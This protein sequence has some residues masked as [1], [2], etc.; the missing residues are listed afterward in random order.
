ME[1][2]A[3]RDAIELVCKWLCIAAAKLLLYRFGSETKVRD[4]PMQGTEQ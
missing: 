2:A 4:A 3:D 1:R